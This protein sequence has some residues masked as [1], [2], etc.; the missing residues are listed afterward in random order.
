MTVPSQKDINTVQAVDCQCTKALVADLFGTCETL[1]VPR[2]F[3][4]NEL[5]IGL[6]AAS[7]ADLKTQQRSRGKLFGR[8]THLR[9][10]VPG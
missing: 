10:R 6:T 8:T 7:S 1:N 9:I 3:S 5:H 2:Y 4:S